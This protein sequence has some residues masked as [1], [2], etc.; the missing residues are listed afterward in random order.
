MISTGL[1][2]CFLSPPLVNDRQVLKQVRSQQKAIQNPTPSLCQHGLHIS[3]SSAALPITLRV[4]PLPASHLSSGSFW[5]KIKIKILLLNKFVV[6]KVVEGR[7][8]PNLPSV[9]LRQCLWLPRTIISLSPGHLLP[10]LP[11]IWL[12]DTVD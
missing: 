7:K 4:I 9:G 3:S 5:C 12:P 8:V 2:P 11:S 10:L 6:N 1:A